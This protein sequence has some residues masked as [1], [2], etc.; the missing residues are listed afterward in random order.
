VLFPTFSFALF[1]LPVF[2]VSWALHRH[3]RAN[4]AFLLAASYVFYGAWNWHFCC[5]LAASSVFNFFCARFIVRMEGPQRAW[6]LGGGIA[7]N[8]GVL[9]YFKYAGFFTSSMASLCASLG[10]H[11]LLPLVAT[12]LPIGISFITFHFISYL[13]DV[14]RREIAPAKLL[15]LS[16]YVSF[17]PHLV[18]G[19][20]VRAAYFLPQLA[21][22]RDPADIR[23]S[24]AL[25]LIASGL[26]K[27]VLVANL[28][29]TT[30]VDPAFLDPDSQSTLQL[31]LGMYGYAVPI[32][33]DFS[34][35]TDIATGI[36]ALFGYRF[37]RNFDNPYRATSL[38]DFWGRWHISLSRWLRDYLYIPLGGS[39]GGTL[40]T[41]A[42]LMTTMVL[43]G[44]WHGAAWTFV[45]WGA[46][47]GLGQVT[48]RL[49]P[50]AVP[51]WL[52]WLLTFHV[53][54]F[55][56]VLF[57]SPDFA[58]AD[59]YLHGMVTYRPQVSHL[60]LLAIAVTVGA[61]ASQFIPVNPIVMASRLAAR[62]PAT[63][64]AA[65]AGG[66][67]AAIAALGP[68]GVPPFIYF[69]F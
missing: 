18:A 5:L 47:H 31:W 27:K 45:A 35:Y 32:F 46:L 60:D 49:W 34:A 51:R 25:A 10:L 2:L 7:A 21:T 24:A 56:W 39:R 58:T 54:C 62:F 9:G 48:A 59:T 3:N 1:F 55:G 28:V 50:W 15:D 20:I 33:C 65:V 61:I 8:L 12:I 37:P 11:P 68:D 63:L 57:R 52:G 67:I 43:G 36:A 69:N 41:S 44:L 53:V 66:A 13:V 29:A 64:Q 23:M 17:F 19:P 30:L 16:L 42:N 6:I 14:H 26:F 38:R 22:P 4:K 40:R